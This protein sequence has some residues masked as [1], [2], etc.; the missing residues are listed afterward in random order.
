MVRIMLEDVATT[1]ME[2][3]DEESRVRTLA[4][5]DSLP[6]A[7]R[8]ELGQLLLDAL[9]AVQHTPPGSIRWQSR[10]FLAGPDRDQLG[11]AV[12]SEFNENTRGAF[13]SW[14]LLR[15]H[16]RGERTPI[17]DLTSVG[18]LLTPHTDGRRQ[19]DTTVCSVTGDPQLTEGELRQYRELWNDDKPQQ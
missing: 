6:I 16:E 17:D 1:A 10:T 15:H 3:S 13:T 12:C 2:D 19:W 18:V 8:T 9:E 5:I 11:F 4:S 14:E 7:H